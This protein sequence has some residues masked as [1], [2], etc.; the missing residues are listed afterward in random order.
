MSFR[1]GGGVDC[2]AG[3][4]AFAGND[5]AFGVVT[6]TDRRWLFKLY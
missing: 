6:D 1:T 3:E 4:A 5:V 2:A